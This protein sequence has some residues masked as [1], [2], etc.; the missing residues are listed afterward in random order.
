MQLP[1]FRSPGDKITYQR[2]NPYPTAD[3]SLEAGSYDD[4][5]TSYH[6]NMKWWF[7]LTQIRPWNQYAVQG[8]SGHEKVLR[9]GMR[10]MAQANNFSSSKFAWI[11]DQTGDIVTFDPRR[12]DWVGEF[13]DINKSVIGFL[14]GHAGYTRMVPGAAITSEYQFFF[15][16]RSDP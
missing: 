14:D 1:L 7:E 10:R 6:M 15:R 12:R 4:V 2:R 3:Y 13:G 8:Y 9:E 11:T 5:G 16:K